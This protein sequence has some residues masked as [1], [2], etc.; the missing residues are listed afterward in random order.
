MIDEATLTEA[1]QRVAD[2]REAT[3]RRTKG[4][5]GPSLLI[6]ALS[7]EEEPFAAWSIEAIQTLAQEHPEN[8]HLALPAALVNGF[9]IGVVAGRLERE[10]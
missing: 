7:V 6:Q 4:G 3:L 2:M 1:T 10:Q 8:L 9:L 5:A